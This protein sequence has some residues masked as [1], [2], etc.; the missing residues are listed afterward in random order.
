MSKLY[1][2]REWLTLEE[3]TSY[4]STM[5][6][7][8]ISKADLYRLALDGYLKLSVD[9]V[10]HASARKGR[11]VK[12]KDIEFVT[13]EKN[14]LL[15]GLVEIPYKVPKNCEL[16]VYEDDWI[17][18]DTKVISIQGVWDLPMIGNEKLDIEHFYQQHTSGLEVTLTGINGAFVEKDEVICQLQTS[19]EKNEYQ[20]GS[21]ANKK[22]LLEHIAANK[23]SKTEAKELLD[24]YSNDREKYLENRRNKPSEEDYYPS[25]GLDEHDYILVVRSSELAN[26]VQSI[27]TPSTN[28]KPMT[29]REKNTLLVLIAALCKEAKID[30]TIRGVATAI[31]HLTETQGTPISEDTIRNVLKQLHSAVE[32]RRK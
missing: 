23:L 12:T 16:N 15:E 6:G 5:L 21:K 8:E 3:A 18:L 1:S 31:K 17:S 20:P 28:K 32:Q 14:T 30:Y 25:G 2:L 19:Y 9:F 13:I 27:E 24:K 26:F 29:S 4:L 7:E 10:N 11:W 22:I